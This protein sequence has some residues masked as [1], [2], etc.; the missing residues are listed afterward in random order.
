MLFGKTF[1]A[2]VALLNGAVADE[3][4]FACGDEHTV[5]YEN[6][7]VTVNVEMPGPGHLYLDC[8]SSTLT[9][10]N[11]DASSISQIRVSDE[12][13]DARDL[14]RSADQVYVMNQ[15]HRELLTFTVSAGAGTTGNLDL[16]IVCDFTG[17][18]SPTGVPTVEPTADTPAPS[19]EPTSSPTTESP[20]T[21]A[22]TKTPSADPTES[23]T[24]AEPTP[25]P[26]PGPTTA[27]PTKAPTPPPTTT[28][29]PTPP[30]TP[31]P[32]PAPTNAAAVIVPN[33]GGGKGKGGKGGKAKG[34]K[35]GHGHGGHGKKRGKHSALPGMINE[36]GDPKDTDYSDYSMEMY[37]L[38]FCT[39]LLL[40]N[41]MC[42]A[43]YCC[44]KRRLDRRTN[45]YK[46][47]FEINTAAEETDTD[48]EEQI[49]LA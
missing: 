35:K 3:Y 38:Y 12:N 43:L 9:D 47:L 25:A 8:S 16:V 30:P 11:G 45:K 32:T 20:T 7:V 13:G 41:T 22:P 40:A 48:I 1:V 49:I 4:N 28:K 34:G 27:K 46:V 42:W 39:A 24:T 6:A 37:T 21:E 18:G 15:D 31:M 14:Q 29:S 23:P 26:T 17:T 44:N 19:V 33:Q 10:E 5:P 36:V 2:L